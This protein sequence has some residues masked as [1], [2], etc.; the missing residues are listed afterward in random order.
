MRRW[1]RR[2]KRSV[3]TARE[4]RS[5]PDIIRT[6]STTYNCVLDAFCVRVDRRMIVDDERNDGGNDVTLSAGGSSDPEWDSS[7]ISIPASFLSLTRQ[8][9]KDNDDET[10]RH[11][12]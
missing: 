11:Q 10:R 2:E 5:S 4:Y 3:T 7:R 6:T 8:C 12:R 1:M 9:S